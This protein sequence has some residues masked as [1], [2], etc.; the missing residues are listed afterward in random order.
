MKR[1]IIIYEGISGLP[2]ESLEGRTALQV[3]RGRHVSGLADAG[4]A[5]SKTSKVV[6]RSFTA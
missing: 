5:V 2:L 4:T 3:A 1:I 6:A